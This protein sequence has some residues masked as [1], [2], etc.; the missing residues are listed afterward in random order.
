MLR[1]LGYIERV[2][3]DSFY[4]YS[5]YILSRYSLIMVNGREK[6][7]FYLYKSNLFGALFYII[8]SFL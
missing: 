3:I 5:T 7:M 8:S 4:P 1:N 2:Y 6:K